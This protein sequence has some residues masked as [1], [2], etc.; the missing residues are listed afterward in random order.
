[1]TLDEW[2]MD[3]LKCEK[4][5]LESLGGEAYKMR[6]LPPNAPDLLRDFYKSCLTDLRRSYGE[7]GYGEALFLATL[8]FNRLT[9]PPEKPVKVWLRD[10]YDNTEDN[11]IRE[12]IGSVWDIETGSAE[13]AITLINSHLDSHLE[14]YCASI[15]KFKRP[16]SR[17]EQED[18]EEEDTEAPLKPVKD[19][20]SDFYEETK[21]TIVHQIIDDGTWLETEAQ[22]VEESDAFINKLLDSHLFLYRLWISGIKRKP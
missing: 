16:P 2:W 19:W 7:S 3:Y 6:E 22:S 18:F 14:S 9:E 5:E 11:S 10:F 1:M 13:E 20:L 8:H 15:I 21:G 17:F 12:I 4:D